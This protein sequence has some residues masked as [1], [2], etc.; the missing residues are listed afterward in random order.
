MRIARS[1]QPRGGSTSATAASRCSSPTEPC[2]ASA[3]LD[4]A[5]ETLGRRPVRKLDPPVLAALR[6]GAYQLGFAG[7][8]PPHAAANESVELVRSAG[9]ERAV[10][11]T[12]AVMRRLSEGIRGLLDSLPDGTPRGGCASPLL[13]RLDR[14][15]LVARVGPGRR[16][17]AHAGAERASGDGR[18]AQSRCS[19]RLRRRPDSRLPARQ[20]SRPRGRGVARERT[21]L[22]AEHRLA[23]RRARSW[24]PCR[25]SA[26]STSALRRAARRS[27]SRR[28][29]P[30]WS[31]SSSTQG[32]PASSRRRSRVTAPPTCVSSRR[33]RA[34]SLATWAASTGSSWTRPARGSASSARGPTSAGAPDRCPS[35]SSSSCAPPS[36]GSRPAGRSRSPSARSTRLENEAVVDALGLST[37]DL[38]AE[39]PEFRHPRRPEFLLTL[40]HVHRTSGFFVARIRP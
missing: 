21:R 30:R 3:T 19:R 31:R 35:S 11:F 34:S 17:R 33:T 18:A 24:A 25:V 40:P 37:D 14:R 5:I 29:P 1:A 15:D 6:L 32:G 22:A 12:N 9:V 26:S 20:A 38:G 28:S 36:S 10:A 2:S 39:W 27:S 13:S 16:A 8:V 7:G 4:H 23:A